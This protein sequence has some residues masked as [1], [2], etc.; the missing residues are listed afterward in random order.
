MGLTG[1]G[2]YAL[3]ASLRDGEASPTSSRSALQQPARRQDL[4]CFKTYE[5]T[6]P[7]SPLVYRIGNRNDEIFFPTASAE[8]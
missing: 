8:R 1:A 7:R 3:P 4:W 6:K 2:V 5:T